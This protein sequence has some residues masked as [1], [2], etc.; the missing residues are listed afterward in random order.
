MPRLPRIPTELLLLLAIATLTAC[1]FLGE[2]L[3]V[4]I[5]Q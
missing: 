2:A 1:G 5:G 4:A 3:L